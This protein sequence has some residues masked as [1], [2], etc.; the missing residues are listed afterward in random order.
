MGPLLIVGVLHMSCGMF[1]LMGYLLKF[2]GPITVVPAVVLI[3]FYLYVIASD[4]AET[5]WGVAAL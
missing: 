4:L 1:G 3:A 5:Q 2:I